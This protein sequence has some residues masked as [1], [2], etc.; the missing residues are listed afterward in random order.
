MLPTGRFWSRVLPKALQVPFSTFWGLD[1]CIEPVNNKKSPG[2][3]RIVNEILRTLSHDT[4]E[5]N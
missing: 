4:Q 2:S 5:S 1:E 3:D